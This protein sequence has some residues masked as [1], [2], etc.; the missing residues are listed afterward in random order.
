MLP[1]YPKLE[2]H[3][4]RRN[5]DVIKGLTRQLA[6]MLGTIDAHIQ[7]EGRKSAIQR[8]TGEL[9]ET[10]MSRLSAETTIHHLPLR[11]FTEEVVYKHLISMA[12]QF[13]AGMTRYLQGFM[14]EVAEKTGNIVDGRDRPFGEELIL[15]MMEKIDHDFGPNGEWRPPTMAVDAATFEAIA[16]TGGPSPEGTRRLKAILERKRDE[17]RRREASR[18]LVG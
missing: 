12:E 16:A 13:A 15:E 11:E 4:K 14:N 6:P 7:F 1:T 8:E 5:L 3:R 18:N 17:F 2:R 10:Q 9:D